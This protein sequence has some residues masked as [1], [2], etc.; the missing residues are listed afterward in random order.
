MPMHLRA[1]MYHRIGDP[2]GRDASLAPDLVSA[3]PADFERQIAEVVS[4]YT[5]VAADEVV[6]AV[7][8]RHALPRGAVLVTFDDGY[9][10][11][12]EIAWPI[13]K[14]WSVPAVL[15]V[16]TAYPD[17]PGRMFWWDALWQGVS[18]TDRVCVTGPGKGSLPL[19]ALAERRSASARLAE[20]LKSL[21]AEERAA[22]LDGLL[23]DLGVRPEWTPAV[24]GWDE[25]RRLASDGVT[26]AAHSRTHALLD[27]VDDA[28]LRDEVVGCRDDLV[29]EMGASQPL[30]AY[31]NGNF[32]LRLPALLKKGGFLT[33]FTTVA[34]LNDLSR[35]NPAFLRR[36]DGRTP[37]GR[38]R[39]KLR[40]PIA[41]LRSWRH[42][43]PG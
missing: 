5:P 15:F 38:L 35:A 39:L 29:R 32:D 13:L 3:T 22:R 20:W 12:A 26:I 25:L 19:T 7:A 11:F 10:D 23:A 43:L 27:Q 6:A 2:S 17:S 42:P 33:G 9:R 37:L 1:L 36:D 40:E 8:D 41:R 30:Y 18:R 24:S 4:R 34:G 28:M 14:R 16:C 31:P 21:G